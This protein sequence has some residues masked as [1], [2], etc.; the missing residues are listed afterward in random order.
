MAKVFRLHEG[1]DGTGWF[2]S[3]PISRD[4]LETIKTEGKDVA[5]SIPSPF[6]RLDLVKSAFS[7]V[8]NNGIDGSSAQHKLVSDALDVA[9]LFYLSPKHNDKI[10]IVSWKPK[11]R[12]EQ[13]IKDGNSTHSHFAE[14][15]DIFWKQD[16]GVYNFD[17][18]DRLYFLLN[19]ANQILGGTSPATLFFCFT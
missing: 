11:D 7:W 4:Q 5:S 1:Q 2:A 8:A 17:K 9:Q 14:T 16:S 15:L 12:F 10:K 18:V 19:N 13:L 6:A 3:N